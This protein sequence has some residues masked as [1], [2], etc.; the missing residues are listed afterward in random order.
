MTAFVAEELEHRLLYS[1]DFSPAALLG[2][3]DTAAVHRSVE[4]S[5]TQA[6]TDAAVQTHTEIA[7]VDSALADADSLVADLQAQR[8]AGRDIEVVRIGAGEDGIDVI[9]RTLEG[10]HDIDAVH[11]LSHGGEGSMQLGNA[12][13]DAAAM[14]ARAGEIAHWGNALT[15]DADL[16]LYGCD[17]AAGTDGAQAAAGLAALTGADVAASTDPT[18]AASAGGN[19]TLEVATG[20]IQTALAPSF[21]EQAQWHGVMATYTAPLTYDP[22]ILNIGTLR[23]AVSTANTNA[24]ADTIVLGS[25][26]YSLSGGLLSN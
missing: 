17:F 9:T 6:T 19:W 20:H 3:G 23:G 10:R 15:A 26:T 21:A 8:A 16:L 25:G 5:T 1:A 12:T 11:V 4:S 13:L 24:G 18:G 2:T 22:V 14:A 7:F